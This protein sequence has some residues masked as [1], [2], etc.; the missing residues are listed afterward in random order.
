VFLEAG[1]VVLNNMYVC[2]GIIATAVHLGGNMRKS[3][4]EPYKEL[5]QSGNFKVHP[6]S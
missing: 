5:K 3:W 2:D 6:L 4:N 1:V